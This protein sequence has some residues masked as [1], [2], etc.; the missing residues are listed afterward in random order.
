MH[1]D[2]NLGHLKSNFMF[3]ELF[4]LISSLLNLVGT[5]SCNPSGSFD[6]WSQ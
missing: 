2:V 5:F 3:E 6:K 4:R 1:L